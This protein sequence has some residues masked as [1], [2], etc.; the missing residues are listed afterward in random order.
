MFFP[1]SNAWLIEEGVL[2]DILKNAFLE[3]LT[4]E[5]FQRRLDAVAVLKVDSYTQVYYSLDS[6]TYAGQ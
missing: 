5:T 2:S 6:A 1:L 3:T 4:L